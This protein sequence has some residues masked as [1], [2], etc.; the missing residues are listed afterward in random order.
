MAYTGIGRGERLKASYME[1]ALDS[2]VDV[3]GNV[4]ISGKKEFTISPIVQERN[5]AATTVNAISTEAQVYNTFSVKADKDKVVYRTGNHDGVQYGKI[6]GQKTFDPSAPLLASP[7]KSTAV[8]C[9]DDNKKAAAKTAIATEAQVYAQGIAIQGNIAT[10][11]STM[12]FD[13]GSKADADNVVYRIIPSGSN[14]PDILNQEI[15]GVK[16]FKSTPKISETKTLPGDDTGSNIAATE[17]QVYKA[18]CW[19]NR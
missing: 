10:W 4:T 11:E 1:E 17:E 6:G 7:G 12:V 14:D 19:C 16:D 5:P 15:E 18:A 8:D 9:G 13:I 2:K 3:T